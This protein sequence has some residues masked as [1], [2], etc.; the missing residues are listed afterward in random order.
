VRGDI[1]GFFGLFIDNLL[2][3]MLV[4]VLCK[5]V[6]GFPPE[7]ITGHSSRSGSFVA[8][9]KSLLFLASTGVDAANWS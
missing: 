6:C 1:D 3:L 8:V 5:V 7:L 2:Q 9:G 4:A